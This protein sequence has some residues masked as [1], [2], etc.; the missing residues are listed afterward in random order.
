MQSLGWHDQDTAMG[1][2]KAR[3]SHSDT[4]SPSIFSLKHFTLTDRAWR[5]L[6][7]LPEEIVQTGVFLTCTKE[8][9]VLRSKGPLCIQPKTKGYRVSFE[10]HK[11]KECTLGSDW[12][13]F[14]HFDLEWSGI[15]FRRKWLSSYLKLQTRIRL[16]TNRV[17]RMCGKDRGKKRYLQ[18][19]TIW[20]V[21][22][23]VSNIS[24]AYYHFSRL[25][26][27]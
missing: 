1:A 3:L 21:E 27:K 14:C 23:N 12:K 26:F 6:T 17:L 20:D 8:W 22:M 15:T 9:A 19:E 13:D 16:Q 5:L 11:I 18:L 7:L 10:K 25:K 4:S 24:V 2:L